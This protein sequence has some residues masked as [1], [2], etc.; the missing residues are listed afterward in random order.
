MMVFDAILIIILAGFIFYGLFFG[1]IRMFGS[2]AA[3]V[4][5]LWLASLFFEPAYAWSSNYLGGHEVLGKAAVFFILYGI[6]NRLIALGFYLIDKF[7]DIL[8]I[9]PFLKTINRFAGAL[10]GLLEGGLLIGLALYTLQGQ[11]FIG[12]WLTQSLAGSEVSPYFVKFIVLLKPIFPEALR[13]LKE[14]F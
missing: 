4:I 10:F 5:G 8:S 1:L 12:K 7:F 9:I 13:I 11:P 6:I 3:V 14:L 2:L